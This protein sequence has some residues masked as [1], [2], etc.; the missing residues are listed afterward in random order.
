MLEINKRTGMILFYFLFSLAIF[1]GVGIVEVLASWLAWY[2]DD[3][4]VI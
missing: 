1:T 3:D 4:I 2:L